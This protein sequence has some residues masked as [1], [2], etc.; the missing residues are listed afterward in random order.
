[1]EQNVLLL[2]S[3]GQ[4]QLCSK[5]QAESSRKHNVQDRISL[6]QTRGVRK[7]RARLEKNKSMK[8]SPESI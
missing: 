5:L 7:M 4:K 3:T 1:M 6:E 8:F 2:P